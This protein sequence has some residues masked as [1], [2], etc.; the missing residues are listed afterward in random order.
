[1]KLPF[2]LL[3]AA[4]LAI[5]AGCGKP[6][7]PGAAADPAAALPPAKVRL[8]PVRAETLPI[9]TEI[10]GTIR[11]VQ[12]AQIAAKLMGTIEELPVALG[13]PVRAGD[14]LVR[15]SAAEITARV[16]QAQSQLNV[17]RR[18]LERERALLTKGASTADLVRGLEDRVALT[19]AMVREAEV[20]LGYATIRAPFAG[21]ISRKL[22]QA[23]DL[24]APG[25]PLLH[26]EGTG[27]FE[28]E[29][30]I[31]DSFASRLSVGAPLAVSLPAGGPSFSA[32]IAELSPAADPSARSI[33]AKLTVPPG[34]AARSGQFARVLLP[35]A[36]LPTLLVPA[37]ALSPL[38][39]M[40]RVFVAGENNRAVLR[41]VRSGA[42][43]GDRL[44]I[45]SGLS[46]GERVVVA[47]PAGLRE[48]QALEVLP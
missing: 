25:L 21:V 39:Q 9:L 2:L 12:H 20:L 27:A 1:M 31:P 28:V 29:V 36:A 46:E 34:T 3:P 38:G 26:L 5:H 45:V 13:Q 35:G 7:A 33:L 16:A 32:P 19:Q 44:E 30:A 47:P 40:E 22:A 18:D 37:A 42:L 6:A 23:G 10:T 11:P 14:L 15:I 4:V 41:L 24:A 48:G 43:R 8:A 17:A